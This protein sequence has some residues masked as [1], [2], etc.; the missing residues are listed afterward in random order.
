VTL[1]VDASAL[2]AQ[3]DRASRR[4]EAVVSVLQATRE[5]LLVSAFVA[6]EADH[7]ILARLGI[8]AELALLAD[9]TSGVFEVA[10]LTTGELEAAPRLVARYRDL[11]IG[12]AD[13][14]MVLLA[15]R[16]RTTRVLTLDERHFRAVMPLQG[17]HFT[18]L[19]ADA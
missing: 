3:A 8:D 14:S 19:P 9:L 1:I 7:V 5:Q 17:G 6:A 18:I 16:L 10:C 15:Q 13:A 4:H 12:L 2:I 11:G